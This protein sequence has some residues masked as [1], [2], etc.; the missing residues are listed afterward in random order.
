[1]TPLKELRELY[2]HGAGRRPRRG[3]PEPTTYAITITTRRTR[4]RERER[5][6]KRYEKERKAFLKR[7]KRNP[8]AP[9]P[10]VPAELAAWVAVAEGNGLRVVRGAAEEW[11]AMVRAVEAIVFARRKAA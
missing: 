3:K 9:A 10:P 2:R 11:T 6:R 4:K 5:L 1:V 8:D 7:Y